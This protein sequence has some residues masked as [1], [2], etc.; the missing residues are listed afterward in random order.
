MGI[1]SNKD[2]YEADDVVSSY[3]ESTE[4]Q[5]PEVTILHELGNDLRNMRMLDIGVGGGRTTLHFSQIAKEYV[6]IDYSVNMI[7]SCK[8][9]LSSFAGKVS[10]RVCDV[11]DM[12]MFGDCAFDFVLFSFNGIDYLPHGDRLQALQEMRRVAK[13]GANVCFSTH[14]IRSLVGWIPLPRPCAN[15][16]E[17]VRRTSRYL[18]H[19]SRNRR[20]RKLAAEKYAVVDDGAYQSRFRTYYILPSEQLK[21]LGELGF[22]DVRVFSLQ[23]GREVVDTSR[24]DDSGDAWLYYLCTVA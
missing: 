19:V 17:M 20:H 13:H 10:F 18:R 7:A 3:S 9:R 15:A 5:K 14:N 22:E 12:S 24:L 21:Q 8:A 16:G 4:L 6:G 1:A 23:S 2:A 11:R